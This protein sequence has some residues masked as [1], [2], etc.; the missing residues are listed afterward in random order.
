MG[1]NVESEQL[2]LEAI[3]GLCLLSAVRDPVVQSNGV[4]EL[5]VQAR[6]HMIE[7]QKVKPIRA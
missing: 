7:G 1:L 6:A 2:I 3:E 4:I 5:V